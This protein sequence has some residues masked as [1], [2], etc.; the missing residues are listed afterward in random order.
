MRVNIL[1]SRSR[2]NIG[3]HF[4]PSRFRLAN[5]APRFDGCLFPGPLSSQPISIQKAEV[6]LGHVCLT[7]C[8]TIS[9]FYP[10]TRAF[11]SAHYV[12]LIT[13]YGLYR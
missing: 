11:L 3:A 5:Y 6:Y 7:S 13:V 12:Y 10:L 4:N 2:T 1:H 9:I 8:V